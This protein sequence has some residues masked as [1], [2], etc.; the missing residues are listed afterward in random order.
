MKFQEGKDDIYW[1]NSDFKKHFS[2]DFKYSNKN[3]LVTKKLERDMADKE[4]LDEL[5]PEEV[6]LGDIYCAL[7]K[8]DKNGWYL[9]YIRDSKDVLWAV[10]A[11]WDAGD[12][13]YV[14]AYSVEDPYR[15]VAGGQVFSRRFLDTSVT[16]N[17]DSLT[18]SHFDPSK[19]EFTYDGV[20]YKVFKK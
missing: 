10:D 18:L 4:V 13:W 6:T 12:G 11:H 1:L 8:F 15:W 5:R 3:K 9:C 19:I 14:F 20:A 16:P 17:G 7:K 2:S